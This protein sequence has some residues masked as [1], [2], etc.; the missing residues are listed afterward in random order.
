M[1]T[2]TRV[3]PALIATAVLSTCWT[4]PG[5]VDARDILNARLDHGLGVGLFDDG[6]WTDSATAALLVEIGRS[7][8]RNVVEFEGADLERLAALQGSM[9][10]EE[11]RDTVRTTFPI[12]IDT[13][14]MRYYEAVNVMGAEVYRSL[15][16]GFAQVVDAVRAVGW[17]DH[18]YHLVWSQVMDSQTAWTTMITRGWVPPFSPVRSW[19]VYPPHTHKTGTNLFTR[20]DTGRVFLS[21]SW[22]GAGRSAAV[23]AT[24]WEDILAVAEDPGAAEGENRQA[25][26]A[27]GVLDSTGALAFPILSE[28]PDLLRRFRE[29]GARIPPR[30]HEVAQSAGLAHLFGGDDELAFAALYHDVAWEILRLM[31]EDGMIVRPTSLRS[32]EGPSL[33]GVVSIAPLEP[34]FVEAIGLRDGG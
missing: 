31:A 8:G 16:P 2:A 5:E 14:A 17:D 30:I 20:P 22:S 1:A 24:L 12:L 15:R 19:V 10:I 13:A 9:L 27:H 33:R 21:V 28:K 25:L 23:A 26:V 29:L 34:G 11:R 32:D 18:A 4:P 6:S 7:G 3:P